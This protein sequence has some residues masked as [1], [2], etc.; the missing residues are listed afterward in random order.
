M[1][2]REA[3]PADINAIVSTHINAFQGFFLTLL[4]AV[5][6]RRL[7]SA[8]INQPGGLMRVAVDPQK[9]IVGFAAGTTTPETFFASLRK[10][11]W[12]GFLLAA[13]PGVLKN[14][15]T[16]TKKLYY[17]LFYSGDKPIAMEKTALLSSI[18]VLPEMSGKKVGKALLADFEEK[19]RKSELN[20]LYLTT[21]KFGN[22]SVIAFYKKADYQIENEFTQPNGRQMLRLV[23][24]L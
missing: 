24:L 20:S 5:F 9:G 2:I 4:G 23:K 22:D 18:A 11:Q 13:I 6:L 17:A 10:N 15:V 1:V 19:I 3:T 8:Y 14:P 7:Y 12:L 16:V 21:D